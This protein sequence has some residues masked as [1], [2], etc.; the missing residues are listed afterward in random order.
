MNLLRTVRLPGM[1][2]LLSLLAWSST[3]AMAQE[4]F[5]ALRRAAESVSASVVQ[6]ETT[7]GKERVGDLFI[8]AG[9]TTG[10]VVSNDGL[11]LTSAYTVVHEPTTILVRLADG[12]RVGAEVV[13]RDRLRNLVLL[14]VP[15]AAGLPVPE[16][17]PTDEIRVGAFAVAVGKVFDPELVNSSVGI[18]SAVDRVWGQAIQTD[19]K[20]SPNNYGGP[21]VDLHGRVLGVIAPLSPRAESELAGFEWYDSG[22]GFAVP[23]ADV[24]ARLDRLA[25]GEDLYAGKLGITPVASDN[26]TSPL[27][28]ASVGRKSP[29][30]QADLRPGDEM[31]EVNGRPIRRFPDLKHAL[32]R[33]YAGETVTGFVLRDGNRVPFEA[34]LEREIEPFRVASLG[35]LPMTPDEAA[36]QGVTVDEVLAG[37]AAEAAGIGSGDRIVAIQGSSTTDL[38][39]LA[40]VLAAFEPGDSVNL[41]I[42]RAGQLVE[43]EVQLDGLSADLPIEQVEPETLGAA[44]DVAELLDLKLEQF[45]ESCDVIVAKD[46]IA[47]GAA[48]LVVWI[49]AP[50]KS[51]GDALL[52]QWGVIAAQYNVVVIAPHSSDER[53][54]AKEDV[55]RVGLL[56]QRAIQDFGLNSRCVSVTGKNAGAQ[57]ASLVFLDVTRP[58][59]G[60]AVVGG[61]I[62]PGAALPE[63]EPLRRLLIA[64]WLKTDVA[65]SNQVQEMFRAVNERGLPMAVVPS[66][67]PNDSETLGQIARWTMTLDRH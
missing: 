9:P 22:I 40:T 67:D 59:R 54:W 65:D 43:L 32:G 30:G 47:N 52:E 57:M 3:Q 64:T 46:H 51:D 56:V 5:A 7:G 13:S 33:L 6:I 62:S 19:A 25:A 16:F 49:G 44:G 1:C 10:V 4:E 55:E 29:A 48:G 66:P 11:I 17:V 15:E 14:R 36:G 42:E 21:L 35:I 37:S 31:I 34:V 63:N 2:L 27:I 61:G 38:D 18:V 23:L 20:I 60:L 53:S 28:L 45:P 8:A 58:V 41:Q 24:M 26:F 39:E 12:R 50:G